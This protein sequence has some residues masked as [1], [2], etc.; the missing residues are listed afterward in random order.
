VREH[1]IRYEA[2][3]TGQ[4]REHWATCSCRKWASVHHGSR[5]EVE[6]DATK[7]LNDVRK[8]RL[9]LSR[10]NPSLASQRD[11]YRQQQDNTMQTP[12]DRA[13][14]RQLADEL[15]HRLG[16]GHEADDEPLPFDPRKPPSFSD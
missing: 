1:R 4:Q 2:S 8:A 3:G 5:K 6:D 9:S 14:F 11:Y 10:G 16:V 13:L 7:H 15:D 12:R